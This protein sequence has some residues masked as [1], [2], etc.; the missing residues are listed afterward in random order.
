[1]IKKFDSLEKT[2][3]ECFDNTEYIDD[4]DI[5]QL[6]LE[7]LKEKTK[8]IESNNNLKLELEKEKTRQLR[9]EILKSQILQEY[10]KK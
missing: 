2:I 1:M 8:Q 10:Y 5:L 6:Q 9:L 4:K 3:S 7:I